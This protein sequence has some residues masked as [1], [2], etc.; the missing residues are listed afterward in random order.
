MSNLLVRESWFVLTVSALTV[1]VTGA[2]NKAVSSIW[3][4]SSLKT[5]FGGILDFVYYGTTEGNHRFEKY[6]FH[7]TLCI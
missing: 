5:Y 2:L 6:S 7:W 3:P 1:T 4:I